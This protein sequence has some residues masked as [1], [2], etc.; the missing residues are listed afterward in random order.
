MDWR[1]SETVPL[2]D[3]AIATIPGF[4][5]KLAALVETPLPVVIKNIAKRRKPER[6]KRAAYEIPACHIHAERPFPRVIPP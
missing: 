2:L 5:D 6:G 3:G 4:D 1:E